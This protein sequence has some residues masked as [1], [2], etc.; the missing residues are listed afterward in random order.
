MDLRAADHDGSDRRA[1]AQKGDGQ[2]CPN[3]FLL[4]NLPDI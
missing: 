2:R 3:T 1:F 4:G